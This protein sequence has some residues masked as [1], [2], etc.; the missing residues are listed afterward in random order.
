MVDGA[1]EAVSGV[2]RTIGRIQTAILGV[3]VCWGM[4]NG[5]PFRAQYE[6]IEA[7]FFRKS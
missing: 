5:K 4:C 6:L 3:G 1:V 7:L 2:G